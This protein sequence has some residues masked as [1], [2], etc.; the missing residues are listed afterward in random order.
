[1]RRRVLRRAERVLPALLRG[2]RAHVRLELRQLV[3]GVEQDDLIRVR[4]MPLDQ[5]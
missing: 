5:L 3:V 2:G 1:M 4:L